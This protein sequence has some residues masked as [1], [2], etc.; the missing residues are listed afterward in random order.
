[1]GLSIIQLRRKIR[2]PMW[3]SQ[4]I[5]KEKVFPF[6]LQGHI[7][8]AVCHLGVFCIVEGP[9]FQLKVS[10]PPALERGRLLHQ[11]SLS[12]ADLRPHKRDIKI[13]NVILKINIYY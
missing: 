10:P 11:V 3:I 9:A 5:G 7:K 6:D 8:K 12:R 2:Q 13:V 4:F 1:M